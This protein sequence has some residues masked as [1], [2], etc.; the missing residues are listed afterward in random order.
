MD[1]SILGGN[2]A[3]PGETIIYRYVFAH[4]DVLE[5]IWGRMRRGV[6]RQGGR[7]SVSRYR[8]VEAIIWVFLTRGR[9]MDLPP[10]FVNGKTAHRTYKYWVAGGLWNDLLY[11]LATR[12]PTGQALGLSRCFA[13]G[14]LV[15][16]LA[17][18]EVVQLVQGP[19]DGDPNRT[20]M[21]LLFL[22]PLGSNRVRRRGPRK[23]PV[24]APAGAI[25][26]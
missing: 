12:T 23:R 26:G 5:P 13:D 10:G 24:T 16:S 14:Q 25:P 19:G 3:E 2:H 17:F 22:S 7:P 9:W 8:A 1:I 11:A 6:G 20:W 18:E 4:R 21:L 15:R